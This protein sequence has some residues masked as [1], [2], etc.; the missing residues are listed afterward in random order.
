MKTKTIRL[1]NEILKLS[2]E[3]ITIIF[4]IHCYL[5][6]DIIILI[7]GKLSLPNKTQFL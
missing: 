4:I 6:F 1:I 7:N 3:F 5:N 2:I